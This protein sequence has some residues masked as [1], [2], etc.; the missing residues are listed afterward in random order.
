MRLRPVAQCIEHHAWLDTGKPPAG[1]DLEDLIHV[2][3]EVQ[4][5]GDI[6]A[7]SR[8]AR[9][10]PSSQHRGIE[11]PAR[12]HCRNHVFRIARDHEA[13]RNLAV[14]RPVRRVEGAAPAIET[15][16]APQ[17]ALQLAFQLE[18]LRE[19]IRRFSV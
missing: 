3:G 17:R 13:N 18:R 12:R 11:F 5:D 15:H 2:L 1:I 10:R 16:L 9:A 6:A 7:L 19:G 4:H 8:K 14:I